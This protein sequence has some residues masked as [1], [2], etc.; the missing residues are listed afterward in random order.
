MGITGILTTIA[1]ILTT[2]GSGWAEK[3]HGGHTGACEGCHGSRGADTN[4]T[5]LLG[6]DPSS[7]CL[8]CHGAPNPQA[9]QIATEPAPARGLAPKA[10]TPGG[11]FA[12]VKKNYSW[13]NTNGTGGSSP[14]ERHG[15]NIVA[16]AYGYVGDSTLH[17]SPGGSYPAQ[18]L[19]CISC[20]DPHGNYRLVDVYG[21][22]ATDINPIGE[23]GSYGAVPTANG[24]V[25][26]YRLLAGKGYQAGGTSHVFA[27]DP[28]IAVAP[29]E[30]NRPESG[31]DTRVAYGKG[32]SK[33]CANCHEAFLQG[34]SMSHVH[35]SDAELGPI[36]GVYNNYIKSGDLSGIQANAYTSL[37]PFQTTE[38]TDPQQLAAELT[39][40]NGPNPDDRVTCLSCHRAHASGWDGI[41]R[42]NMKGTFITVGGEYPGID[43]GGKG[44]E[45]E[46]STG[47]LRTEYKAAMYNR[48]PAQ[49]ATFQRQLCNKCH[50]RD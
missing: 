23:S 37:V 17:V 27:H 41:G 5:S 33:W 49:F 7:T 46:N 21:T 22:I 28:P 18:S 38:T 3:F 48:D 13:V 50:A 40:S 26:S 11:D 34:S 30:Y 32:V 14:G 43:A 25:G 39:S 16:A 1:L 19:S 12:Y 31:R 24:A 35:P 29:K 10:M 9:H 44:K 4:Y 2:A 15:H 42:W 45:G 8:R 20:H 6:P 36:A 47:K